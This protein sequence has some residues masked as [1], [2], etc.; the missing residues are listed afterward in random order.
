MI[1][2]RGTD[3]ALLLLAAACLLFGG[4]LGCKPEL[5]GTQL[6]VSSFDDLR[7]VAF[8]G[9][10][11]PGNGW[12]VLEYPIVPTAS[13]EANVGVVNSRYFQASAGAEGCVGIRQNT[14]AFD[15]R[16]CATYQLG[17]T[18]VH[19]SSTLGNATANCPLVT[20]ALLRV[21]D[22]G[23]TVSAF[24]T[25]PGGSETLLDDVDSEWDPGEKWFQLFGGYNLGKGA[26]VGF[27]R[28]RY[29]SQG[30]FEDSTDGDIAFANYEAFRLGVDGFNFLAGGDFGGGL[31]CAL[32]ARS[33]LISAT[34]LTINAG[35]FPDTDVGKR[36]IKADKTYFK[37]VDKL[38][39]DRFDGYFKSFPK[40]ADSL[41]CAL[42]DEE[43]FLD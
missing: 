10:K 13:I 14:L 34:T 23:T 21:V 1:R 7:Y 28:L 42:S 29:T 40:V 35:A 16:I 27:S 12:A 36:L 39:P 37:T 20:G 25:C 17:P 33:Q 30:P 9:K 8:Y 15:W 22:N 32:Q 3:V 31:G 41:A 6:K 5:E 2:P 11:P 18:N 38:F 24:Y 4:G 19:I 43:D 26:E